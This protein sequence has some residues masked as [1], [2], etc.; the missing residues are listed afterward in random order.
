[1]NVLQIL[2]NIWFKKPTLPRMTM[3]SFITI[4]ALFVICFYQCSCLCYKEVLLVN[5]EGR[6]H[7]DVV[8]G[9]YNLDGKYTAIT[10]KLINDR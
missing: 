1:M 9:K 6:G 10:G 3:S 8:N 5:S 7:D 2:R 4:L